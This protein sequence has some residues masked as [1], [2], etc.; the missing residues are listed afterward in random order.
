LLLQDFNNTIDSWLETLE[1]Y[2]YD[3]FIIKPDR[4]SWSLGQVFMHLV[5][6]MQYYITEI[7]SCLQHNDNASEK[8]KE[9]AVNLFAINAF[10]DERMK[11]EP[12]S[13]SKIQQPS[14]KSQLQ[15]E[16]I[17]IRSRMN[18]LW[19]DISRNESNG[20]TMHPGLGYFNAREWFQFAEVHLRH[21]LRQK[22]RIEEYLLKSR[23]QN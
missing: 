15:A 19:V 21:H 5:N 16:M 13:T 12:G 18:Q 14:G 9:Q 23:F 20:K 4:E 6:E 22:A 10:P 7:E 1:Q 3:K 8:M 17:E 11:G 2:S